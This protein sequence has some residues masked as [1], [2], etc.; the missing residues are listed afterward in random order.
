[1]ESNICFRP[2]A[3]RPWY[4]EIDRRFADPGNC[5][6]ISSRSPDDRG[7]QLSP[8]AL[9]DRDRYGELPSRGVLPASQGLRRW[10]SLGRGGIRERR[11]GRNHAA[12]D[13]AKL[14]RL[15]GFAAKTAIRQRAAGRNLVGFIHDGLYWPSATGTAFY[16]LL[17][18]RGA[19][20]LEAGIGIELAF[21]ESFTDQ[22]HHVPGPGNACQ[23]RAAAILAGMS[24]A[25]PDIP[26]NDETGW[27]LLALGPGCYLPH[28]I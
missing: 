8:M 20:R 26:L 16:D 27:C 12:Q 10:T 14:N 25:E 2:L 24:T 21:W 3:K 7:R 4:T 18:A 6:E 23:A 11:R 5:L 28:Q 9:R 17:W 15:N 13:P 19:T 22:F 1:M